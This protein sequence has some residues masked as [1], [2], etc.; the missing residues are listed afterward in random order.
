MLFE[1]PES[2]WK[3]SALGVVPD[4]RGGRR[5]L[6][7]TAMTWVAGAIGVAA[8][9]YVAYATLAWIRYGRVK[10]PTPDEADPLLDRFMPAYDVVERGHIVVAAPADVTFTAACEA[11]L[12]RSRLIRAVFRTRALILGSQ[13]DQGGRPRGLVALTTSLGWM[14]LAEVGGREIVV[15][16][17]TKPWSAN[18]IFRRI[19]PDQFAGFDEPGLR[20][21]RLDTPRSVDRVRA[22]DLSS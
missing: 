11:D 12:I 18:V 2:V 14:I 3:A 15:G 17:V 13:A 7:E 5:G 20:E 22:F 19:A 1:P 6:G 4:A 10:P 9:V 16:T 21:N 8:A